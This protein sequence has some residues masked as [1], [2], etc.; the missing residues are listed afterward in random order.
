MVGRGDDFADLEEQDD[1][2]ILNPNLDAVRKT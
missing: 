2:I 1:E